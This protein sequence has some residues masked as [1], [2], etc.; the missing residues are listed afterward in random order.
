MLAGLA[1]NTPSR[2]GYAA[3]YIA[4]VAGPAAALVRVIVFTIDLVVIMKRL[5][6]VLPCARRTS[7]PMS[8][9]CSSVRGIVQKR[10]PTCLNMSGEGGTGGAPM[11]VCTAAAE[12]PCLH[13][14]DGRLH[15]GIG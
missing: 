14:Y 10:S 12:H 7:L 3:T 2:G 4:V 13:F 11:S 1:Q 15:Y 8:C 9:F 5:A 6:R